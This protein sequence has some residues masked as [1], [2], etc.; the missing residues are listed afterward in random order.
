MGTIRTQSS[1]SSTIRFI[2]H[3][4]TTT[5]SRI[6]AE[7]A[8]SLINDCGYTMNISRNLID[9]G[10]IVLRDRTYDLLQAMRED[11]TSKETGPDAEDISGLEAR[12][13]SS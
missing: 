5:T 9:A 7:M 10:L 2:F 4:R 11:S 8:S 3:W 13:S 12:A 1:W 6:T